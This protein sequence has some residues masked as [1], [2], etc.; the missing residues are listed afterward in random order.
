MDEPFDWLLETGTTIPV[1]AAHRGAR[2]AQYRRSLRRPA[3]VPRNGAI[4]PDNPDLDYRRWIADT[5]NPR[6]QG[7][8]AEILVGSDV[9]IGRRRRRTC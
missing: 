5:T 7:T 3:A 6:A 4:R 1:P 9:F 8:L 2:P